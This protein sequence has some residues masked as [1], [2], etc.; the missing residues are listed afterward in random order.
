M[1]IAA[2]RK[3][4]PVRQIKVGGL[5]WGVIE[6]KPKK[7]GAPALLMLPGTLGTAEIWWNQI[8]A[9][10]GRVHIV[11]VTYPVITEIERL[12]DG[13][14]RLQDHLGIAKA[15]VVGSSLGGFL[16]QWYAA[17]HPDKVDSIIIGNSLSDPQL[18][19][20]TGRPREGLA[21]LPGS[22]HRGFILSS[23]RSW[24]ESSPAIATLKA[25]LLHSGEKL[26]SAKA[27]KARVLAVQQATAVPPIDLAPERIV[28]VDCADDPLIPRKVQNDV[29]KRYRKGRH[30]RFD[31]G[32][33][34]PYVVNPSAY[35][36]V[37]AETL[38]V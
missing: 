36:E 4:Y 34:Y 24:P 19:N 13:L 5:T 38:G 31:T 20:P 28:V 6:A 18:L 29:V 16:T 23:V 17:R 10:A 35:T 22:V 30:V 15:S 9:L 37:L 1:D 3:K 26:L 27:L 25:V 14:A 8:A 2:F 33:H 32:Q 12:A 7:K 21:D 11:S